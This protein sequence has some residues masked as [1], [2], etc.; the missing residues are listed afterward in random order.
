M[1]LQG[2]VERVTFHSEQN[3][4]TV[5]ELEADGF[6]H[7]VV[8]VLPP[9]HAGESLHVQGEF[10]EHAQFGKQFKAVAAETAL[11]TDADAILRYLSSGAVKG[12][13]S[14][15]AANIVKKFGPDTLR[16][17]EQTP[18][19]LRE[20]KGITAA[21]AH[22]IGESFAAQFG[23]RE[24]ML[25]LTQAGL[26]AA[27]AMR[28][29]K[30]FGAASV[31]KMRENPYILCGSGLYISFERAD[32][33]AGALHI[34]HEDPQRAAAGILH[35]LRHN[36]GN[37]H[38]CL[39]ADKLI[40]TAAG[41]L[42]LPPET[43]EPRLQDMMDTLQVMRA[44]IGGTSFIFLPLL[45]EAERDIAAR[46]AALDGAQRAPYNGA[47]SHLEALEARQGLTYAVAQREAILKAVSGA[48]LI[49]TGGPGTGK[50][51]A[52][53]AIIALLE[54][55]GEK[56]ALAAPTGRAA[57]R[58]AELTGREAK[59]L[60]R[61]LEVQWDEGETP[62]FARNERNPL[63]VDTLII[64]ELSMVDV[65]LFDSVLKALEPGSRLILVGDTQQLPAVG[66]GC[67]L[68]D[69]I[70]G[71]ALPVVQLT[72]VFRQ[73]QE[74]RIVMNAH[75]IV[76]GH[77]P[78][79]DGKE[80]DFFFL[81]R[82]SER[83]VAD[84]VTDLCARRLPQTYGLPVQVLCPGKKGET[85]TKALCAR[86]QAQLNPPAKGKREMTIEERVLR[87]GDKVMHTRNNYDIEWTRD[88]GEAGAGVFNGDIGMLEN[89]ENGE[90]AVRYDDR[91]AL[92]SRE[93]ALDLELAYAVTVHKSQGSE[94][95][96]VVLPLYYLPPALSYRN[97]LY[98]A[99]TRAKSLLVLVGSKETICRMVDN[100]KRTRRYTAL[101]WFLEKNETGETDPFA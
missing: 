45:Y 13:G 25:G 70:E 96:I 95:D 86:L 34:D 87:E 100:D 62:I 64:D 91:V 9:L 23:L 35:V 69:L 98:T 80:G 38:T 79:L 30:R 15:T 1:D 36:T 52:L 57:K 67:V 60:H 26:T 63:E 53:K 92:Y 78:A 81:P 85:G 66:P 20:V 101:R 29:Y 59:T 16:V 4:F 33:L 56:V 73:A 24:V 40:V 19:R 47:Q 48:G 28:V 77:Y 10:T 90:L 49:L 18:E 74:S 76:E 55:A 42:G 39:P 65:P 12:V 61:L 31:A 11:P 17:I 50:T 54:G 2:T 93:D 5:L 3:G 32:A 7:T 94:F 41:L 89:I 72:E 75:R 68:Q 51:T 83:E 88:D 82:E 84:T 22:K 27:E 8:G 97:L 43:V 14:A 71:H 37:G 99:V 58:M 46:L 44:D 6:V 21:K